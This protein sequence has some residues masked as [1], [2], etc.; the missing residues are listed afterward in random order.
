MM[1]GYDIQIIIYSLS[2]IAIAWTGGLIPFY[3]RHKTR[4][5]H[6]F[7]SFGAGVLLGASFLHMIPDATHYIGAK[8]GLPALLGFLLLYIL[9]KFIMTHPCPAEHCEYHKVGL[10][11]FI[12]L[13][14]HSLITGLALGAGIMVP[15]LGFIVFLAVLFHKL[16]A[17]LSLTSLFIKE[18]YSTKKLF[19]YLSSFSIMVPLGT[20]IT[21]LFLRGNTNYQTIGYLI[22]FSAGT[23]LHVAADDLLPEVHQLSKDRFNRLLAFL[24]G[25]VIIW[26]V[27]LID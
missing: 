8:V 12:G 4:I 17:S 27:T 20:V 18:H 7:I 1:N 14:L 15:R 21:Y 9:E 22:A 19:I 3:L 23:F 26:S 25:L 11:A 5:I 2:I 10:T 16:P 24:L 6:Y 13:S